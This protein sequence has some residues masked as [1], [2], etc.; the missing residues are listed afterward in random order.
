MLQ[1]YGWSFW[2]KNVS[3]LYSFSGVSIWRMKNVFVQG[4]V[5][6]LAGPRLLPYNGSHFGAYINRLI[7]GITVNFVRMKQEVFTSD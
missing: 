1:G 5:I 7:A 3:I 2:K 6:F 4:E